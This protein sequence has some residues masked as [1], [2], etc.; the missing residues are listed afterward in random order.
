V[1]D[2]EVMRLPRRTALL[3]L[4]ALPGAALAKAQEP[5]TPDS[6]LLGRWSVRIG[7]GFF[8][9]AV[10]PDGRYRVWHLTQPAN[11][12]LVLSF[13]RWE[14]QGEDRFCITPRG[15][16]PLCGPLTLERASDRTGVVRWRVEYAGPYPFDWTAY[17]LGLAP[18]DSLP[19]LRRDAEIFE[20]G[21]VAER[22]R[23]V[24]CAVP[25][26]LPAG[27]SGPV[28]VRTR[29]VVE[30]DSTVSEVEVL[31]APSRAVGEA[32][33]AVAASCR[34]EPGRLANGRAVRVRVEMTIPFPAARR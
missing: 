4:C 22:P 17:P 14:R 15:R 29:F 20:P 27:V 8:T 5:A 31:D 30:P 33:R 24:G 1:Y 16:E 18:W 32:A 19:A 13:G 10:E 12:T 28:N 25:L 9:L 11:D 2:G 6:T 3:L 34:A 7:G 26:V 23:L 21:E